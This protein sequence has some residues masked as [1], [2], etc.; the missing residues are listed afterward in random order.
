MTRNDDEMIQRLA[1]IDPVRQDPAPESDSTRYMTIKE[2]AVGMAP[3]AAGRVGRKRWQ[4]AAAVAVVVVALVAT[5]AS[6]AIFGG[7]RRTPQEIQQ[8][9]GEI[10]A[11]GRCTSG[12]EASE[13][14]SKAFAT[15]GYDDWQVVARPEADTAACVIAAIDA[16]E[17]TVVLVPVA[18]PEISLAMEG[19]ASELMSQCLDADEATSL[20]SSVL[21]SLGVESFEVST[22][23]PAAYPSDQR[24]EVFEHLGEGCAVYSGSGGSSDGHL[25]FYVSQGDG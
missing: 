18:G 17:R 3:G 10:F 16:S 20:I 7:D 19:V 9:V 1:V 13:G 4:I 15:L 14:V 11:G 6:A 25:I 12:A 22:N 2:R 23:G 8:A 21:E 24:A 5:A